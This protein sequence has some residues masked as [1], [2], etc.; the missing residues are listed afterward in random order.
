MMFKEIVDI[1]KKQHVALEEKQASG[2]EKVGQGQQLEEYQYLKG[3]EG[4]RRWKTEV[5][6]KK[7]EEKKPYTT[8]AFCVKR[9]D[10]FK[11]GIFK[12]YA[13]S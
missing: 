6:I 10:I 3:T 5:I 8:G 2:E 4:E 12:L 9:S 13:A 1:N 11:K 7:L